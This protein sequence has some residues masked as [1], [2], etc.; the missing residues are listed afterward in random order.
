MPLPLEGLLVVSVEQAVAAPHCTCKLADAGARVIKVERP[1]GDFARGYDQVAKGEASYFVWLNRG[2][3]SVALDLGKPED[4]ALLEAMIAKADVFVQN[5]K[6]GA[7]AK[8]GFAVTR[9]RKDYA[10]LI[11]CSVSG[12]GETGPFAQRKAYDLLIQA[13]SGVASVT[14][15]PETAARVGVSVVDIAAGLNAYE[16]ILEALIAR[17]RSGEGAEISISMFDGMADWMTVPLLQHEGGKPPKRMGLAHTSISPYGV[18]VTRDGIDILISIQND[19]EWR[20]LAADV[21]QDKALAADPDFASNV[22]RVKRRDVTDGKV[23]K[24][25]G[26]LTADELIARLTKAD[27]AFA[28][29][30]GPAELAAH[31]HL[32][33]ITVDTA[34]GPVSLPSPAPLWAGETRS[35]GAVPAI[36]EHTD[37]VR[38]EF[39]VK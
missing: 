12:Y 30:N 37:K 39:S 29:V 20:I 18:F 3:E 9:L 34:S 31:P 16:A 1:E 10:K 7:L 24:A 6:P 28:R 13:E 14:G 23:G 17:G 22:E 5:L 21:M 8:L 26:T 36:G 32:R 11:C 19:R 15:G 27:I 4:K 33:R 35:Y 25:F 38:R 2:K